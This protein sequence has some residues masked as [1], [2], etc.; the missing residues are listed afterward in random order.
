MNLQVVTWLELYEK[1]SG[2]QIDEI[3]ATKKPDLRMTFAVIQGKQRKNKILENRIIDFGDWL[4]VR[5]RN[6]GWFLTLGL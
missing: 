5:K 6:L 2:D 4:M 1:L 3:D